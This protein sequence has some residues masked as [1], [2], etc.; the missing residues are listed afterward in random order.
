MD[1][2]LLKLIGFEYIDKG[3]HEYIK[4]YWDLKVID[5]E[6]AMDFIRLLKS[7]SYLTPYAQGKVENDDKYDLND[8]SYRFAIRY[9]NDLRKKKFK[10]L[11]K[12]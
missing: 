9:C 10:R 7:K 2:K 12:A 3:Y 11:L 1:K 6:K 5:S 8:K 4:I